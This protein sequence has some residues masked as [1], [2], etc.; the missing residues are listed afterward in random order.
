VRLRTQL[1]LGAG[2][3]VLLGVA[4]SG[5]LYLTADFIEQTSHLLIESVEG[6]RAAYEVRSSLEQAGSPA[7]AA[8][9]REKVQKALDDFEKKYIAPE[10]AEERRLVEQVR[11]AV[12][13]GRLQAALD[14][15]QDLVDF[16]LAQANRARAENDRVDESGKA[17]A[18]VLAAALVLG[19]LLFLLWLRS[20]VDRRLGNLRRSLSRFKAGARQERLPVQGPE[21]LR[22]IAG[23]FNEMADNLARQDQ[24]Q[25]EFLA[26]VAHDLRGP[27]NVLKLSAQAIGGAPVLPPPEQI[28]AS[29]QRVSA[30]VD[31][32][33]RMIDD[34]LDRTRIEAGNLELHLD[35]CDVRPLVSEVV[36]LHRLASDQHHLEVAV[37]D[38]PVL[39]RG[40]ATRLVQVMTNLLSNA[41]KYS[42]AGGA[43]RVTLEAAGG[44]AV[45]GVADQ[46]IGIAPEDREHI[47][48]PFRRSTK[49]AAI[50]I[51]GVGLGLSVSRRLVQ[52]HG[53][54]IEVEARPEGGSL[55]RIRLP[56]AGPADVAGRANGGARPGVEM[57]GAHASPSRT[58]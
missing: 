35:V 4:A 12:N 47:F 55:F 22:Q 41:I 26:G 31:H 43:I 38:E 14:Q 16:N 8:R 28:R 45:I 58:D 19:S 57:N 29:L 27:L 50:K 42:P 44:E 54:E 23:E 5:A 11:G 2:F 49:G 1:R 15:A 40:D 21:E 6:L 32:L 13:E 30:Q 7:A 9:A 18:L 17:I 20:S 25:L 52:A 46:G 56:L 24:L 10:E 36:D 37:P 53:G 51:P 48:E 34:L 3:L 39:V 33:S